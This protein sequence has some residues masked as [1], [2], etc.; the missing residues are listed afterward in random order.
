MPRKNSLFVLQRLTGIIF[1]F[2]NNAVER[3]QSK[4]LERR[5][6]KIRFLETA[7]WGCAGPLFQGLREAQLQELLSALW[8]PLQFCWAMGTTRG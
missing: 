1:K 4:Q 3:L 2:V 7:S 6:G 8:V 5:K